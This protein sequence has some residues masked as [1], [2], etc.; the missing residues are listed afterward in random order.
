VA[1]PDVNERHRQLGFASPGTDPWN[2]KP[3]HNPAEKDS[4]PRGAL[5]EP[6][7][8][9]RESSRQECQDARS[10]KGRRTRSQMEFR[11]RGRRVH[12]PPACAFLGVLAYLARAAFPTQRFRRCRPRNDPPRAAL[13]DPHAVPAQQ[14]RDEPGDALRVT[15]SSTHAT[16]SAERTVATRTSVCCATIRTSPGGRAR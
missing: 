10:A 6:C 9:P 16:S 11:Y 8:P 15:A 14:P 7:T 2:T 5:V 4:T 3:R 13:T 1:T 12:C